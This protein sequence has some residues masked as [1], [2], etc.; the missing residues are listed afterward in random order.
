MTKNTVKLSEAQLKKV[1]TESVQRVLSELDWK[2]YANAMKKASSKSNKYDDAEFKRARKF[3][4]AAVD[5]FNDKYKYD[6]DLIQ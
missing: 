3:Q 5:A 1:I 2:T 4:D 6:Y